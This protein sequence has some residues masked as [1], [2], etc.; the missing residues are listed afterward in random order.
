MPAPYRLLV[1]FFTTLVVLAPGA[2]FAEPIASVNELVN[3]ARREPPGDSER[4]VR[5]SDELVQQERLQTAPKSA[6]KMVFIDGSELRLDESSQ[7]ILSQ[8]V[9][10]PNA[11]ASNGLLKLGTG[12]FRFVSG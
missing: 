11:Q 9:F 5:L 8:Y 10:D 6:V 12:V 3:S 2:G 1:P 7:M 4:T